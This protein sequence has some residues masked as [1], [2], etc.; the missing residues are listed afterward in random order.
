MRDDDEALAVNL[1]QHR[2]DQIQEQFPGCR[3]V[4]L[5]VCGPRGFSVTTPPCHHLRSRQ[6]H[7]ADC[8][9]SGPMCH[10]ITPASEHEILHES[11][12]AR[13]AWL[14][15]NGFETGRLGVHKVLQSRRLGG[16]ARRHLP[17]LRLERSNLSC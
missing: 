7:V 5:R 3:F 16:H 2:L 13:Y 17:I 15:C 1:R 14:A 6:E 11:R 9:V 8:D 4:E 10:T 12:T